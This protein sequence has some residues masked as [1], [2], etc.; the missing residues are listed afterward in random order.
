VNNDL[1]EDA[2]A[3]P[4]P[5][6]HC[7]HILLYVGLAVAPKGSQFERALILFASGPVL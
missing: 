1:D 5:R 6:A 7:S 2:T 4:D 3:N